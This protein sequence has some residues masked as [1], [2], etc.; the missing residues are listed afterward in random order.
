M[1][2]W[3][4]QLD[5]IVQ[6]LCRWLDDF[7][8]G[9]HGLAI[10]GDNITGWERWF[11]LPVDRRVPDNVFLKPD[12][13]KSNVMGAASKAKG[14]RGGPEK[15]DFIRFAPK[16]IQPEA[17]LVPGLCAGTEARMR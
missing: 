1:S 15:P 10:V 3:K 8:P 12:A 14:G 7:F 5:G 11:P 4:R 2:G 13:E 17:Y 6:G 9:D 16:Y